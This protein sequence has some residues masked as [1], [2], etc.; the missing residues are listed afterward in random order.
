MVIDEAAVSPNWKLC[1]LWS[2]VQ[3]G[4]GGLNSGTSSTVTILSF[5]DIR[6][7]RPLS[8]LV[9]PAPVPPTIMKLILCSRMSQK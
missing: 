8:M 4:R 1:L 3:L 9:F 2:W 7:S 6:L 5:L